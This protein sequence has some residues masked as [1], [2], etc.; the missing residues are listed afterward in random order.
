MLAAYVKPSAP[1]LQAFKAI[2]AVF[3]KVDHAALFCA[4]PGPNAANTSLEICPEVFCVCKQRISTVAAIIV[5]KPAGELTVGCCDDRP[6]S[7]E[8]TV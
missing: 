2:V 3:V 4:S 5:D 6:I 1:S 7:G 8:V